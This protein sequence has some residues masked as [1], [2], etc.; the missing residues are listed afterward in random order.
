MHEEVH[1]VSNRQQKIKKPDRQ[2]TFV[3]HLDSFRSHLIRGI[4]AIVLFSIV[5]FFFK[6]FIFNQVILSPKSANFFTNKMLCKAADLIS[7]EALC[8]N[9]NDFKIINIDLSG[10][11]RAHLLVSLIFGLL[12]AFPYLVFQL[13]RF[14]KPALKKREFVYSRKM[15]FWV[16]ILFTMGVL[17]GYFIIVP[18]A[19]NFLSN[20]SVSTQL[21]NTI[22]FSS[23]FSTLITTSLGSG[24]IFE[25]PIAS[26][27][28][29]KIGIID[30][31]IMKKYRKHAIVLGFILSGILT[32]PDVFSQV[33]VAFPI[34][35][36]YE[37]SISIVKRVAKKRRIKLEV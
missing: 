32:P 29:A 26:Y 3:E 25:I 23:Y 7:S 5:A 4:V 8:I 21:E 13:W 30:D 1:H 14:I 20:Y 11:F 33:L 2:M 34:I 24:L 9:Q 6:D 28:L 22:T 12:V 35:G 31:K 36:L 10:Q 17:F 16:S 15:V 19:I 18:L 37:L 27:V